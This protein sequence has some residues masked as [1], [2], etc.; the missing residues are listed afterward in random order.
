MTTELPTPE[1]KTHL[2]I[3]QEEVDAYTNNIN[4]YQAILLT[5][6]GNWDADLVQ[7]KGLDPHEAAKSCPMD[8]IERLAELQHHEQLSNLIKTEI[9]ERSKSQAILTYLLSQ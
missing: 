9:V 2:E 5:L 1:Q 7:F 6:D 8:K 3:R 4:T